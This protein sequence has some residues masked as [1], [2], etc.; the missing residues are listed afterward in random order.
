MLGIG[1]RR[2]NETLLASGTAQ[3]SRT[4]HLPH[5]S[6]EPPART[7]NINWPRLRPQTLRAKMREGRQLQLVNEQLYREILA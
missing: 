5:L 2:R 6:A 3:V 4:Q 1:E 7:V